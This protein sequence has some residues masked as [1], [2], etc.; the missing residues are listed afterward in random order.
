MPDHTHAVYR[1][2]VPID[3]RPDGEISIRSPKGTNVEL[4]VPGDYRGA[5]TYDEAEPCQDGD[6]CVL[7]GVER[8]R[9]IQAGLFGPVTEAELAR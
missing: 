6:T 5:Y 1:I 9:G 3:G 8:R 4:T 7:E 2:K